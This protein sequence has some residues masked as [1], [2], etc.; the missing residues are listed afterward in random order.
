MMCPRMLER[1]NFTW[2]YSSADVILLNGA[3]H[4]FHPLVLSTIHAGI[5]SHG[6]WT[7]LCIIEFFSLTSSSLSDT[8]LCPPTLK[9]PSFI[10]DLVTYTLN[11]FPGALQTFRW[12][13]VTYRND[14]RYF[15]RVVVWRMTS[16]PSPTKLKTGVWCF[17]KNSYFFKVI[18]VSYISLQTYLK[19]YQF[20]CPAYAEVLRGFLP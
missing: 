19:I 8:V 5:E 3:S 17:C 6:Y 12:R 18:Y 7:D 4:F 15:R 10:S 20:W 1:V 14:L 11:G 13:T 16:T 9:L 2:T